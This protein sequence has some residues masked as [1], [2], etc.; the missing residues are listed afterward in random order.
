MQSDSEKKSSEKL[1]VRL[2]DGNE[3]S[4]QDLRSG[5]V[6]SLI[7]HCYSNEKMPR[8]FC[9]CRAEQEPLELVIA[10]RRKSGIFELRK[11]PG[12]DASLHHPDCCFSITRESHVGTRKSSQHYIEMPTSENDYFSDHR[13]IQKLLPRL[14]QD[15]CKDIEIKNWY[16]LKSELL[17]RGKSYKVNGEPLDEILNILIPAK[18]SDLKPIWFRSEESRLLLGELLYMTEVPNKNSYGIHIKGTSETIWFNHPVFDDVATRM[19]SNHGPDPDHRLLI[20]CSIRKSSSGQSIQGFGL[21][22]MLL[23]RDFTRG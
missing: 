20:L 22:T 19:L 13:G 12:Q 8:A 17:I 16:Q 15:A 6:Q 3:F 4:Q 23:N 9:C 18:S 1:K 5:E 2:T 10:L 11:M 7:R 14:I 21:G